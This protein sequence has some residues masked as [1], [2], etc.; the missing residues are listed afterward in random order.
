MQGL[1]PS[2][3]KG[4][5]RGD[6]CEAIGKQGRCVSNRCITVLCNITRCTK[7]GPC[8]LGINILTCMVHDCQCLILLVLPQIALDAQ[9]GL[10]DRVQ[11]R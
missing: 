1:W 9:E 7:K 3:A 4:E 6:D 11:I 8:F 10:F 5:R 2:C